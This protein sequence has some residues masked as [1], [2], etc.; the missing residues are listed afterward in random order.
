[1]RAVGMDCGKQQRGPYA[2]HKWRRWH[3]TADR[4][5][6]S[7]FWRRSDLDSDHR[8]PDVLGERCSDLQLSIRAELAGLERQ[9]LAGSVEC[10]GAHRRGDREQW[11]LLPVDCG[12]V[13][14]LDQRVSGFSDGG[15]DSATEL[16]GKQRRGTHWLGDLSSA[17]L[18]P[19][20]RRCI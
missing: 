19:A 20:V 16:H 3:G 9:H 14:Q 18:Q 15:R 12:L 17:G 5:D 4:Y 11:N 10:G 2:F 1:M 6:G 13:G 7:E 8:W